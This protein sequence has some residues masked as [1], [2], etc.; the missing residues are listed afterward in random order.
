MTAREYIKQRKE[1]YERRIKNP[2]PYYTEWTKMIYQ[3]ILLELED[4]LNMY[5]ILG[6]E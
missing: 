5:D 1:T 6:I 2:G 3:Q 4:I